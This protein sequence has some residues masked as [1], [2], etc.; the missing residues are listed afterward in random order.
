MTRFEKLRSEEWTRANRA[1]ESVT[2]MADHYREI[3]RYGRT[4]WR[5]HKKSWRNKKKHEAVTAYEERARACPNC[6]ALPAALRWF[7]YESSPESWAA[8]C[9]RAGWM[10]A[11]DRCKLQIDFFIE[12]L[13]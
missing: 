10:T 2:E 9:G 5:V 3:Q 7:P 8:L 12:L 13:N 4:G 6:N 1:L 11:C